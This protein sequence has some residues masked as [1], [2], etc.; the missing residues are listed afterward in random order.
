MR[1]HRRDPINYRHQFF[2]RAAWRWQIRHL[3]DIGHGMG[4]AWK[5]WSR[6]AGL[7]V[8]ATS[9]TPGQI[10]SCF[11][12]KNTFQM[13]LFQTK[14]QWLIKIGIYCMDMYINIPV[15]EY[16][17]D[18]FN[19]INSNILFSHLKFSFF[20]PKFITILNNRIIS[21]LYIVYFV[22][23]ILFGMVCDIKRWTYL[24]FFLVI[25]HH[26]MACL[27]SLEHFQI[28]S[29]L[30]S[31]KLYTLFL[32][33]ETMMNKPIL[34]PKTLVC[35]YVHIKWAIHA[36]QIILCIF[37]GYT[38]LKVHCFQPTNATYVRF[39]NRYIMKEEERFGFWGND[40]K[41]NVL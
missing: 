11:H 25:C 14:V 7:A 39:L 9:D 5:V 29:H 31:S 1:R 16:S 4:P 2:G 23:F 28:V 6:Y 18:L 34:L 41:M 12:L 22:L 30:V 26:E 19:V 24:S 33:H 15:Y 35:H 17:N 36:L 13:R 27:Q 32:C 37:Q 3:P 40:M 8:F 21:I 10:Y 38:I 20:L